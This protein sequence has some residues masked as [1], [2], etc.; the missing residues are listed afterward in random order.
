MRPLQC[1]VKLFAAFLWAITSG[2]CWTFCWTECDCPGCHRGSLMGHACSHNQYISSTWRHIS[3]LAV[4]WATHEAAGTVRWWPDRK[5]V[6]G[7]EARKKKERP[8]VGL[9]GKNTY[10]YKKKGGEQASSYVSNR[11]S[12]LFRTL[13]V[14]KVNWI[15]SWMQANDC[16][17]L[18]RCYF[19]GL[20]LGIFG[21]FYRW[22]S[23]VWKM[24]FKVNPVSARSL[25]YELSQLKMRLLMDLR[26][27]RGVVWL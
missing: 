21:L 1:T 27:E 17:I 20:V 15:Q 7:R 23:R 3:A 6:V 26:G 9:K 2:R 18:R 5:L 14:G 25:L 22:A 10:C 8:R 13:D 24:R 19:Y 4:M 11:P 16:S 12:F